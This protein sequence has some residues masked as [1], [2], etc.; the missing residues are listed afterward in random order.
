MSVYAG[1][2]IDTDGIIFYVDGRNI[3]SFPGDGK[4]ISLITEEERLTDVTINNSGFFVADF[5][6]T[7][8]F[9]IDI[10]NLS[11]ITVSVLVSNTQ[12]K[13]GMAFSIASDDIEVFT[14]S[15]NTVY[16][17]NVVTTTSTAASYSDNI[18]ASANTVYSTN[19]VTT[20]A[21][22]ASYS[23]NIAASANT[24]YSTS[25]VTTTSTAASYS[26]NIA[27]SA[28]TVYSTSVVTTT[29]TGL[30]SQMYNPSFEISLF[31]MSSS[32]IV[33]NKNS[34]FDSTT[35][36]TADTDK[37]IYSVIYR[38]SPSD[39]SPVSLY[40]NG[41][42]ANEAPPISKTSQFINYGISLFSANESAY[43]QYPVGLV[44]M[45]N[46]ALNSNEMIL[47]R[48]LKGI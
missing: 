39:T 35:T 41:K 30:F 3:N 17:T 19:V 25:V 44:S 7:E 45:Y 5:R 22:T 47:M 1:P 12:N 33:K 37:N 38:A 24:V 10:A 29:A 21:T 34:V 6:N 2:L 43:A 11:E 20:T 42:F 4:L 16:S 18:A 13:T 48:N 27:A 40:L 46:R 15:A 32:V 31:V 23:D 26:D 28:N 8:K 9:N 36:V 14:A